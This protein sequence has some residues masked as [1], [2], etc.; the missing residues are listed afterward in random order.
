MKN[1]SLY[2]FVIAF[3]LSENT[4]NGNDVKAEVSSFRIKNDFYSLAS[5]TML[6][7]GTGQKGGYLAAE[8]IKKRFEEAGIKK[9]KDSYFQ[10]I[11]LLKNTPLQSSEFIID[12]GDNKDSLQLNKDYLL[13]KYSINAFLPKNTEMVFA[14]YGIIA[15]E[16]DYNDYHNIDVSGKIAVFFEGE[17]YSDDISYFNGKARTIHSYPEAKFRTAI[18][19]GAIASILIPLDDYKF[20]ETIWDNTFKDYG[21]DEILA[22]YSASFNV[23][24]ILNPSLAKK[25]FIN[26]GY[27]IHDINDMLEKNTLKSFNF[28]ALSDINIKSKSNEF[29]SP[30]VIGYIEGNN[31][32][33]KDSYIIISAHYDHFG[34]GNPVE[35]DSIYNGA[36][37]NALGVSVLIEIAEI[38]SQNKNNLERSVVFMAVT[39]EEFG[40]L[41]S[42]YYLDN[43]YF[44]KYKT[45][46]NINIDG[47]PFIDEFNSVI[48]VGSNYSDLGDFLETTG[49]N[50]NIE[51]KEIP[52][53]YLSFEAFNR[54]DQIAYA[55]AGIPSVLILDNLD[56]KNIRENYAQKI[57]MDFF[58]NIYH[59][60]FD[61]LLQ[62]VNYKAVTQ[63]T[64]FIIELILELSESDKTPQWYENSP[65]LNERLR[66]RAEKK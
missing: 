61:D 12:Y 9:I 42:K 53:E 54:S 7:R 29:K 11:P 19:R 63:Y 15:P 56:Y 4:I 14:G 23:N 45:I 62:P 10:Q 32:K 27:N 22:A 13:S 65:F 44:P 38:L 1:I 66:S 30:N 41:G 39:G 35:G 34:V 58:N 37:D 2:I 17:P 50:M 57:L 25:L 8:F 5:D 40:L 36:L 51:V 6:G 60:P 31:D 20:S 47:V 55:N 48:G 59:T 49:R 21:F 64:E 26:E 24:I 18:S 46:A 43:P 3:L 16:Y 28:S 52:S 33:K